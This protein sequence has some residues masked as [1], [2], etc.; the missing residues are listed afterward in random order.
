MKTYKPV[1]LSILTFLLMVNLSGQTA[2]EIISKYIQAIGGKERLS[3]ITSLSVESTIE[4]MGAQGTMKTTVLNG[5]GMKMSIEIAGLNITSC[6]TDKGGWS[7]NTMTGN[8]AAEIMSPAQY[9]SGKDQII[10]GGPF[11]NYAEKG[12]KVELVG[13]DSIAKVNTYKIKFI[14]PDSISTVYYF[15]TGTFNLVQAVAQSEMQGQMA[16]NVTNYSDFR[17]VD[18]YT[19]PYK[20]ELLIAQQYQNEMIVTKVDLN[21]P[22]DESIFK[23]PE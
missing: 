19:V 1:T 9:N 18:G 13:T 8:T 3:K 14:S 23:K 21:Q 10:I 12:Y 15:D 5:K 4:A 17:Q 16:E 22:V 2:D 20:M 7:I 11:I 6:Y